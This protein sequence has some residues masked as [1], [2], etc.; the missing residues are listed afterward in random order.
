MQFDFNLI[1]D[2]LNSIPPE[3]IDAGR[4]YLIA[5]VL[6]AA[7]V[8]ISKWQGLGIQDKLLI[9]TVRGTIQIILMGFILLELFALQNLWLIFGVLTLMCIA[10]GHTASTNLDD[11]P[12]VFK[13][14]VPSITIPTLLVMIISIAIG[15]IQPIGEFVI[16]M[17]GML[18]GN[19]MG[20]T[21]LVI[22]RM[23][24]NAQKERNLLETA[25]SLGASPKQA[26]DATVTEA[27]RASFLPNLNRYAAL[28]LA[29]IPG[30]MSGMIAGGMNPV[31][32]AFYQV[33][34]FIM[35]FLCLVI[36]GYFVARLFM[37]RI[38]NERFQIDVPAA[39]G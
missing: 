5:L 1:L 10:A 30:L 13:V 32:A 15:V 3:I 7:L 25:L 24:S 34:I 31:A 29:S 35:I 37:N 39:K 20:T 36:C 2:F 17:G 21:S 28:G 22:E 16:P 38:F 23:W 14:A 11:V 9:G 6:L 12:G 19:A 4:R 26:I 8:I 18:G 27:I 33:I